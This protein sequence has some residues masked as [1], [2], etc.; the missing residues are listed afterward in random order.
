VTCWGESGIQSYP[1]GLEGE[2][3]L[4]SLVANVTN[5]ACGIRKDN[6]NILCWGAYWT[7]VPELEGPFVDLDVWV[8]SMCAVRGDGGVECMQAEHVSGGDFVTRPPA[9]NRFRL[10]SI[11]GN[12]CLLN[13]DLMVECWD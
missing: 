1:R 10:I 6:G 9:G 12:A 5:S 8:G 3:I 2:R 13:D 7:D 11:E 4:F